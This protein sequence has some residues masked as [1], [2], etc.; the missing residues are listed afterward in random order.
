MSIGVRVQ[1]WAGKAPLYLLVGGLRMFSAFFAR[2]YPQAC[3]T[4]VTTVRKLPVLTRGYDVDVR[5]GFQI[6]L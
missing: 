5:S 3:V 4:W 2:A 6:D 1:D